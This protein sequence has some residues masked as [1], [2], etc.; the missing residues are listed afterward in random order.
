MQQ[1]PKWGSLY[2]YWELRLVWLLLKAFLFKKFSF[3]FFSQTFCLIHLNFHFTFNQ[4]IY[5]S[6]PLYSTL[7]IHESSMRKCFYFRLFNFRLK[8]HNT[9]VRKTWKIKNNVRYIVE[10]IC[11][12]DILPFFMDNNFFLLFFMKEKKQKN[13]FFYFNG[14]GRPVQI[15]RF[16]L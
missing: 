10:T 15:C 4:L 12:K 6:T 8:Y 11:L 7:V 14:R 9:R 2:Y 5:W 13:I 1:V 16:A 3:L